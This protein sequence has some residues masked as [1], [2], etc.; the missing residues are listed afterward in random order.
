M[1]GHTKPYAVTRFMTTNIQRP[2]KRS[3]SKSFGSNGVER[4]DKDGRRLMRYLWAVYCLQSSSICTYWQ[5]TGQPMAV[6]ALLENICLQRS[7]AEGGI[8]LGTSLLP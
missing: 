8:S 6:F 7:I 4:E 2:G 3:R 5:I 1:K